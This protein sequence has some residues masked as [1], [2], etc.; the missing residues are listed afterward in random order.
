MKPTSTLKQFKGL[1]PYALGNMWR[2]RWSSATIIA[3]VMLVIVILNAFLSMARGFTATAKSAGS[4][5]VVV[6]LGNHSPT[7]ANSQV[8][9]EQL[10]LLANAPGIQGVLSPE[11]SMTVSGRQK[12]GSA[13][14][15]STLRGLPAAGAQMRDGFRIVEGRMFTPGK[16]ELLVGRKLSET[17]AGAEVGKQLVLA[18]RTWHVVGEYA[19]DSAIFESEY[20]ADLGAV[21]SAYSRENQLQSVRGRLADADSQQKLKEFIAADARLE[22]SVQTERQLYAEQVKDT[23][24]II[25]YLGWPLAAILSV[26]ALAGVLNTM[27]IVL[28]G[29]RRSLS[30]LRMLGFAPRAVLLSVLFETILLALTG[31]L[32]G[33]AIVFLLAQGQEA[34]LMGGGFTTITYH[35]QIDGTALLQS[36]GLAVVIG[37]VG[38]M[39]PGLKVTRNAGSKA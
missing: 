39:L 21:Q 32:L 11:L 20:L 31:A 38:G 7:E 27:L 16:Y 35:L 2:A 4:D 1:L 36:L 5:Q 8:S 30:V 15:N 26:G 19:L 10:A 12:Q 14:V 22:L 33:T 29:R 9:M 18:G 13:K 34:T 17:V 25:L 37:L 28:E 24:S 3:C 23:S 6:I